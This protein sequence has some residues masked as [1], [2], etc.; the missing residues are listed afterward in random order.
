VLS[1]LAA[2]PGA[3]P[4]FRRFSQ[5]MYNTPLPSQAAVFFVTGVAV[6]ATF[7]KH[8]L[9]FHEENQW[10]LS[11]LNILQIRNMLREFIY[12]SDKNQAFC[13]IK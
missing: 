5:R 3:C 10:T 1:L 2:K 7:I 8:A 11:A 12:P 13:F 6:G 4:G 9:N